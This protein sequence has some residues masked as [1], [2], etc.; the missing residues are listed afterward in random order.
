MC[1]LHRKAIYQSS[2][3]HC[4]ATA[5]DMR[6]S[7]LEGNRTMIPMASLKTVVDELDILMDQRHAYLNKRTGQTVSI[8]EEEIDIVE[9]SEPIDDDK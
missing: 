1:R 3:A 9:N 2:A 4:V 6:N 5:H 8:S 7:D